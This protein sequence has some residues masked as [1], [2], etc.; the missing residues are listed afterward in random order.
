RS[1]Q[2]RTV[3]TGELVV[4]LGER[5]QRRGGVPRERREHTRLAR[6][7][8]AAMEARGVAE[9]ERPLPRCERDSA[10]VD[11][12]CKLVLRRIVVPE[13][14]PRPE[15]VELAARCAS[16]HVFE[17]PGLLVDVDEV[18]ER[19]E[20]VPIVEVAVPALRRLPFLLGSRRR[21]PEVDVLKL[22]P[23]AEIGV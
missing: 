18:D 5:A 20:E 14:A 9:D 21:V 15:G 4:S 13:R 7:E 1:R 3:G 2:R 23:E 8:T 6:R 17:G 16:R 11:A 10:I 22:R 19:L 12:L